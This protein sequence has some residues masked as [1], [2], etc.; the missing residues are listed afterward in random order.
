[1]I[2]LAREVFLCKCS[3]DVSSER[4]V[5]ADGSR[6]RFVSGS[7][8]HLE[9]LDPALHDTGRLDEFRVRLARGE[10]WLVGLLGGAIATYTWLHTRPRCEYPYLAGCAFSLPDDYGY[11]YDAWTEPALRGGGLRRS[12]FVEELRVLSSLG[13]AWEAS[14]FVHYQLE[15]AQRSLAR[16]CVTVVPLWR[17]AL[18]RGGPGR[19]HV[20]AERLVADGGGARPEFPVTTPLAE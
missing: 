20:V 7:A 1:M 15:G 3:T 6:V 11:G 19:R 9:L 13:K 10:Y 16:A 14:F 5:D 18:D 8:R 2:V 4:S 12:A 17:V